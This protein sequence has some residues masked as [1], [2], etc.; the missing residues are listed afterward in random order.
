MS[1]QEQP[2]LETL[3]REE[4][5]ELLQRAVVGRVGYVADGLA[6]ILPVNFTVVDGDIVF[7]TAK[8]RKL[9][10]LSLRGRLSFQADESRPADHEGWSV[11]VHGVARE[12]TDPDEL[13]A[14]RRRPQLSW[15]RPQDEHW[16]RIAV[17]TISGRALHNT[18]A[19]PAEA[20]RA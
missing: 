17:E 4:C 7:C 1:D 16:V 18:V 13:A 15:V 19:Q 9:S 10:W 5:L 20:T 3:T 11:L 12:V 2:Q 14:L 8:G 6:I